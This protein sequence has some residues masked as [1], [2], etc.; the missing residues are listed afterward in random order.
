LRKTPLWLLLA[1]GCA[2]PAVAH[3]P[4]PP[5]PP[6]PW[7]DS[8]GNWVIVLATDYGRAQEP[9]R[10]REH[11]ATD[12]SICAW[13]RRDSTGAPWGLEIRERAAAAR[14]VATLAGSDVG[15]YEPYTIMVRQPDGVMLIGVEWYRWTRDAL[16]DASALHMAL[17]RLGPGAAEAQ[18]VLDLALS[19]SV[20]IYRCAGRAATDP[21]VRSCR[22]TF[23]F[24]SS[25]FP[26]RETGSGPPRYRF[27]ATADTYP[28]SRARLMETAPKPSRDFD[29]AD[30]ADAECTFKRMFSYDPVA[31]AYVPDA[32]LPA[33]DLYT[34]MG[35]EARRA[36]QR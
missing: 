10:S 16:G 29:P 25:F 34:D 15:R 21:M 7:Q 12:G 17:F 27:R 9:N 26:D 33:C 2:Q 32:P 19:G 23:T 6:P 31:Q 13:M 1:A 30:L 20:S 28:A 35:V 3:L 8:A 11:C 5:P 14:R 4:P 22:G 36:L 24:D 18:R